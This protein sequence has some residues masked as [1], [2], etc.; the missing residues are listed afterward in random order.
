[1][2][3]HDLAHDPRL[4]RIL[5]HPDHDPD[6]WRQDFGR[7]M[8]GDLSPTRRS[9]SESAVIAIQRLLIFL[10]HSTS[11]SGAFSVD[12]DFGRGTNRGIAQFRLEQGLST[13]ISRAQLCYPCRWN[14]ARNLIASVPEARLT[15]PVLEAM[16][17]E[18]LRRCESGAVMTGDVDDALFHLNA[19]QKRQFLTCRNIAE[20]YADDARRACDRVQEQSGIKVLPIWVLSIVRQ[21]TAGVMRPRFEQHYLT[22]LNGRNPLADLSEIRMQSMSLGLGQIMGANYKRVGA[23][24]AHQLFTATSDQQ[25]EFVAR[26]LKPR[27]DTVARTHPTDADFRRVSRFYNGPKYEAHHYHESLA[28]WFNEFRSLG[29]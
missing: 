14:T 23:E 17:N 26:F 2:S 10:G 4:V 18:A 29:V 27:A 15:P 9:A 16:A 13:A 28:R 20:R 21:E 24:T 25:I 3:L 7:F 12:G 6:L 5:T 11:S 19:L 8:Q 1:M 22:R